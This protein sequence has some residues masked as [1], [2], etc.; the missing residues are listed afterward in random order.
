MIET[1]IMPRFGTD[2]RAS[3]TRRYPPAKELSIA[4]DKHGR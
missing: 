1:V 4:D 3:L 2:A